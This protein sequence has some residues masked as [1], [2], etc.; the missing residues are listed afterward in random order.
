MELLGVTAALSSYRLFLRKVFAFRL[1]TDKRRLIR[2]DEISRPFSATSQN[3]SLSEEEW[4]MLN[5]RAF[6][7]RD[8]IY[9][10]HHPE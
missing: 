4:V 2:A 7:Q 6:L 3:G 8:S 9:F 5:I 1:S 10:I